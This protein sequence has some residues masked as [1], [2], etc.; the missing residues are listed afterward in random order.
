MFHSHKDFF[1]I[2]FEQ[3]ICSVLSE[4]NLEST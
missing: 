2:L 3:F 1:E 4:N